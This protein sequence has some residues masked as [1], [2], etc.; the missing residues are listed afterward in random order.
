MTLTTNNAQRAKY[1]RLKALL[2][3]HGHTLTRSHDM[4]TGKARYLV[5]AWG[6]CKVL[7]DLK[8]VRAFLKQI[9]GSQ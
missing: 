7:D 9:G 2:K 8:A 5:S 4:L 6:M 1:A 3:T